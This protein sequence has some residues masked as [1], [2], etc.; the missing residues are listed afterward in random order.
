MKRSSTVFFQTAIVL[1]GF[2]AL[3]FLLGEPHLEGRNANAS[4]FAVYF[5]D[6]FLAYVYLASVPLFVGLYQAFKAVGY[7]GQCKTFSHETVKAVR[8]VKNCALAIIAFV[9]GTNFMVSGDPDDGPVG[10][11]MRILVT[12]PSALV[13]IAAA[14]FERT[15]QTRAN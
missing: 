2:G 11:I 6:P 5:K 12:V 14:K 7:A 4:V 10:V 15:A 8:T 1:F 3:A 13:A 9:A